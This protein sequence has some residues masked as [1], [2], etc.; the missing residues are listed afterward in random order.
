M[1]LGLGVNY[2]SWWQI[3]GLIVLTTSPLL[4]SVLLWQCKTCLHKGGFKKMKL[5]CKNI[6]CYSRRFPQ[7]SPKADLWDFTVPS[8][9]GTQ[10][11]I[12]YLQTPLCHVDEYIH[13][14]CLVFFS[15]LKL[16]GRRRKSFPRSDQQKMCL[17]KVIPCS[18]AGLNT[19]W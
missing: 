14:L 8:S 15:F 7:S 12:L 19:V 18:S 16:E 11:S 2:S 3:M 13:L 4:C 5:T 1:Q 9:Q 6:F 10:M 17:Q